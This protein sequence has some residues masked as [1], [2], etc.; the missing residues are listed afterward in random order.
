MKAKVVTLATIFMLLAGFVQAE[1]VNP[2]YRKNVTIIFDD[3]GSMNASIKVREEKEVLEKPGRIGRLL[4]RKE[5]LK[6]IVKERDSTRIER[7]K[8]A[9]RQFL[10]ALPTEYNVAIIAINK[11]IVLSL[12]HVDQA[13][14]Q[15][16]TIFE[17]VR[18]GGKT[19]LGEAV[20]QAV[21]ML[22]VQ[23]ETQAGLGD[24]TILI[25]TDGESNGRRDVNLAVNAAIE[26]KLLVSTIGLD[27]KQHQL[28]HTTQFVSAS[29]VDELVA[30]SK[31]LVLAEAAF[32][33]AEEYIAQDF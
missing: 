32:D 5:Q 14:E 28:M 9:L 10:A 7:A 18:A 29:S 4:G 16:E 22:N 30:A 17:R 15:L 1:E 24:Y 23:K 25:I 19:P 20:D 2:L 33:S 31:K 6:T 26:Q 13:R 12:V 11:G 21:Q 8:E 3:S 27:M